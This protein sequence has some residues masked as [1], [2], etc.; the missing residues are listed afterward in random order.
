MNFKTFFVAL[1]ISLISLTMGWAQTATIPDLPIAR[2]DFKAQIEE[3]AQ[4]MRTDYGAS[5]TAEIEIV[6]EMMSF[7][8]K[9]AELPAIGASEETYGSEAEAKKFWEKQI[10]RY[11][12]EAERNILNHI[13]QEQLRILRRHSIVT[14][15]IE[16]LLYN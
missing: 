1:C 3:L 5:A 8:D 16:G 6:N 9:I 14:D 11:G 15:L 7:Y 13:T 4:A 2:E 10:A 12:T